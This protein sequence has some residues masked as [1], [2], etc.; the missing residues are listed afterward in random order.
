MDLPK[1]LA[2]CTAALAF[3]APPLARAG[4]AASKIS[5]Q[6][7]EMAITSEGT[8]P[9]TVT[10]KAGQPLKLVITRKTDSTCVNQVVMKDFSVDKPLPLNRAVTVEITP[11]KTGTYSL[12]CGMGMKFAS[13]KVE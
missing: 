6:T 5:A 9:S 2:V 3:L 11:S 8:V 1:L 10:V 4:E 7:V 13:L 12:V